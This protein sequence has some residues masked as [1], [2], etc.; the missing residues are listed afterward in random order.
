V[1]AGASPDTI[2]VELDEYL[3]PN[4]SAVVVIIDVKYLDRVEKALGKAQKRVDKAI[5]SG[6]YDKL[7]KAL[8]KSDDEIGDAVDS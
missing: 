4:S 3:P 1:W 5:D 6:D 8:A 7:Q 2:C